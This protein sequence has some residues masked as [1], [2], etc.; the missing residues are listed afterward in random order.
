M[1]S[2]EELDQKAKEIE[3]RAMSAWLSNPF[4]PYEGVWQCDVSPF[5]EVAAPD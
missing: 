5:L 2:R 4:G 3:V 1:S